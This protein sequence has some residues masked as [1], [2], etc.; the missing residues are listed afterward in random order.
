MKYLK[1]LK[2]PLPPLDIQSQIVQECEQI[3]AQATQAQTDI[4]TARAKIEELVSEVVGKGYEMKKLGD[5]SISLINPSKTEIKGIDENIVVS[6]V[7]MA[8]VSE[9]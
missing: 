6:F 5:E 9:E 7:E 8:S 4:T 1:S 2:I 3:D